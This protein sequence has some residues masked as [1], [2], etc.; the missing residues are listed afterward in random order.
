MRRVVNALLGL[1]ALAVLLLGTALGDASSTAKPAGRA[2]PAGPVTFIGIGGLRWSDLDPT[3][4]PNLSRLTDQSAVATLTGRGARTDTCP[5]DAW[6]TLNAGLRVTAKRD[7]GRCVPPPAPDAVGR[8]PGWPH[9]TGAGARWGTL[10]GQPTD[11]C[12]LGPGAAVALASAT[13]T[14]PA[15]YSTDEAGL[16]ANCG[17]L[18]ADA[19]SLPAGRPA[20]QAT[21][22]T[23]DRSVGT[24]LDPRRTVVLAGISDS[25]TAADRPAA[26]QLTLLAIRPVGADYSH[27]RSFLTGLYSPSTRQSGLVQLTDLSASLSPAGARDPAALRVEDDAGYDPRLDFELPAR[28]LRRGFVPFFAAFIGGQLLS[29]GLI[30]LAF[31][32]GLLRLRPAARLTTAV[33]VWFGSVAAMSL[34]VGP[35][36]WPREAHPTLILG[37]GIALATSVFAAGVGLRPPEPSTAVV[38]VAG[39]TVFAM[40][41]DVATGS[42]RQLFSFFGSSMLIAGRFYGFGNIAFAVFAMSALVLAAGVG[43]WLT[44][45][46]GPVVGGLAAAAVGGAAALVDG[47]PGWGT[48]LGGCASLVPGTAV[49]ALGIA[50][51]RL[52]ARVVL[53][54]ALFALTTVSAVAVVDWRRAP[55]R[56]THL[57][58]FVQQVIDGEGPRVIGHKLDANLALLTRPVVL[59]AAVPLVALAVVLVHSPA[60]LRLGA[61]EQVYRTDPTFR[62][63]LS[64]AL[65]TALLGFA[66][67]DSGI[68]VPAVAAITGGPLFAAIWATRWAEQTD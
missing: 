22:K 38:T 43:R 2:V 20:R 58:R 40:T 65:T 25:L 11:A 18:V 17:L 56:R 4:T 34:L 13:E 49:L 50:G 21:L 54:V 61:L 5:V 12:A 27:E 37:A 53:A 16:P 60:R 14:V 62:A 51:I 68:I 64:A 48:D 33:G 55:D 32:S 46:Q 24:L 6:L 57:G 30:A 8:V 9:L 42:H 47:W 1:A 67:N 29:F 7:H 23:V 41:L 26:P 19:G 35:L 44:H 10:A 39:W 45:R 3:T 28:A 63:L 52:R 15:H 31:R 59:L 66:L 36:P